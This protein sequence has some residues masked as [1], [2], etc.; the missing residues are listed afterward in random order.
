[1]AWRWDEESR[2]QENCWW[3]TGKEAVFWLTVFGRR[4]SGALRNVDWGG[5]RG[6]H[7]RC[8]LEIPRTAWTAVGLMWI[9]CRLACSKEA[10]MKAQVTTAPHTASPLFIGLLDMFANPQRLSPFPVLA[11]ASFGTTLFLIS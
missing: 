3:V 2:K 10:C 11:L 5:R 4:W 7:L 8:C 9:R 6:E 1:M